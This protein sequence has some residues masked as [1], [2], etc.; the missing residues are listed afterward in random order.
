MKH[1]AN[2][3][4]AVD[5]VPTL[6]MTLLA[7]IPPREVKCAIRTLLA[8][9]PPSSILLAKLRGATSAVQD[10][11]FSALNVC[12]SGPQSCTVLIRTTEVLTSNTPVRFCGV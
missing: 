11:W 3:V 9:I 2:D 8:E 4:D 10:V 6:I 7:E 5:T 1:H 12:L